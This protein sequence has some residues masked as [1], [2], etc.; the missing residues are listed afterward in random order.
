MDI[1]LIPRKS[2]PC[3]VYNNI[4]NNIKQYAVTVNIHPYKC[5]NKKRWFTYTHDQQRN[6]LMRI[7]NKLRL[8]NPSIKL[9]NFSFEIAPAINDDEY[10][11]I[12]F[13]ALYEMPESYKAE[14]ETYYNRICQA[15]SDTKQPWKHLDI[16]EIYSK[17]GWLKYIYKNMC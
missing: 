16:Q 7:E 10:R 13:H 2:L 17:S 15:T 12:H 1:N 6:Q 8:N 4:D 14:L 5:M 9:L 11:N 3:K